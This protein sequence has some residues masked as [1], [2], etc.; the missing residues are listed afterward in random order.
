M[1]LLPPAGVFYF[2]VLLHKVSAA[3]YTLTDMFFDCADA[4]IEFSG[5]LYLGVAIDFFEYKHASAFDRQVAYG[6][7]EQCKFF[8]AGNLLKGAVVAASH[9]Y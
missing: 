7:A 5:D 6:F 1:L 2:I 9:V 4:Y 3:L 8:I